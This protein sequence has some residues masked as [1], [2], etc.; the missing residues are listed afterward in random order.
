[1]QEILDREEKYDYQFP[2]MV[3]KNRMNINFHYFIVKTLCSAAGFEEPQAQTIA[4]YSQQVDD[5][6]MHMPICV[7]AEPPAYLID[8]HY[9]QKLTEQ[10]WLILPHPTGI[11]FVRSLEKN[12]RHT[13]LAP[14]HFIP[15]KTISCIEEQ[16]GSGNAYRCIP[17]KDT[18]AVLI[19]QIVSDAVERAKREMDENSL[20][21]LGMALHTYA[22]TYA[23]CHFSGLDGWENKA[24]IEK[25]Y[26]EHTKK[27]EMPWVER[28]FFEKVPPIGHGEAGTA[29]D[30]CACRIDVRVQKDENDKTLSDHIA[31]DNREWFL[32]CAREIL[33]I[34]CDCRC[35]ERWQDEAW[36]E[37]AGRILEAMQG[38][39]VEEIR[40]EILI[41]RWSKHFPE[42]SYSYE[43]NQRFFHKED[44]VCEELENVL[45]K[46]V[47]E[48]FFYYNV[49]AYQRAE[50]VVGSTELLQERS[51]L[52]AE[53]A[54]NLLSIDKENNSELYLS[55]AGAGTPAE[56]S[57]EKCLEGVAQPMSPQ[58]G[59][60]SPD[61]IWKPATELGMLVYT[62]GFKYCPGKDIICSTY[63]NAQRLAGYCRA[64]DDTAPTIFSI[65]DCEPIYFHYGE[66]EWMLELWKGQYGIETGCEAGLYYRKWNQ[67][68]TETEK[69]TGRMYQ[70]V[71]DEHMLDMAFSL[72]KE[73]KEL[74]CRDWTKHWWLT[75]FHWG[76]FSEPEELQMLFSVRFPSH[77]M[78]QAFIYGRDRKEE[79]GTGSLKY[80]LEELGY[81][82]KELDDTS[83][84]FCFEKPHSVQ[85][86]MRQRMRKMIQATNHEMV[87]E[88]EYL[89]TKYQICNNDPNMISEALLEKA[90]M[91][92]KA[93]YEKLVRFY[94][95]RSSNRVV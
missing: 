1:M 56:V 87:N 19:R 94:K 73:G 52:L 93:F 70:C 28:Q 39:A 43:K 65:I 66:Y 64:Y 72:R 30:L 78:Q 48:A 42:V 47:T 33:D 60:T 40:K 16:K 10:L 95:N 18:E 90:G 71:S 38:P 11:D 34:L 32:Q 55:H 9:A 54:E 69:V 31:R 20:M 57:R 29:P 50:L 12:Y 36:N 21:Q 85:A 13:T 4:Y 46:H 58:D 24:V 6:S 61:N 15:G 44:T 86:E 77:E 51:T 89:R 88:Y 82:Y 27:E 5:F 91:V 8:R 7:D 41:P 35:I 76:V 62:A 59:Q 83:V 25:V 75:G 17:G 92:E 2:I 84:E 37:L 74:F 26:N 22:D 68:E 3:Q 53:S 67:P 14:F 80:G 23:H 49:L 45:I 63:N 81:A 79:N